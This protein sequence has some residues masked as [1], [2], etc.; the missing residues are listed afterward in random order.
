[1]TGAAGAIRSAITIPKSYAL[2]R[3]H[4]LSIRLRNYVDNSSVRNLLWLSSSWRPSVAGRQRGWHRPSLQP[5]LK[6]SVFPHINRIFISSSPVS[7]FNKA[8]M[9]N[10]KNSCWEVCSELYSQIPWHFR[11]KVSFYDLFRLIKMD[12]KNLKCSVCNSA[13]ATMKCNC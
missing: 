4:S 1:M 11:L 3:V 5:D 7:V 10:S 8:R 2:H 6:E 12:A 9:L 13:T